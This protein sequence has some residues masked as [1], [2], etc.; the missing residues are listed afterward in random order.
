M[1]AYLKPEAR[2]PKPIIAKS[3]DKNEEREDEWVKERT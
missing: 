2:S 1:R 3:N